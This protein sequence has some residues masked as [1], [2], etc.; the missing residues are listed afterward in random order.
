MK[1]IITIVVL[2]FIF[3]LASLA[4]ERYATENLEKLSQEELNI[5][6]D[7]ALNLKKTEKQQPLLVVLL[8][9]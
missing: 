6:L 4:Q 2:F 5:Y 8:W 9:Q 3:N 7:E 1:S